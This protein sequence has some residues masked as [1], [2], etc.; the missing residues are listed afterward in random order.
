MK[1]IYVGTY[2]KAE[3]SWRRADKLRTNCAENSRPRRSSMGYIDM[4]NRN[5]KDAEPVIT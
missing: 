4:S 1:F 5:K 3:N 2:G